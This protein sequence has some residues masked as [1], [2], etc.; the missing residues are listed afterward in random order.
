MPQRHRA[1]LRSS[2]DVS[3][4]ISM[5][6]VLVPLVAVTCALIS[7][8]LT[9]V[10]LSEVSMQ[11]WLPWPHLCA[12]ATSWVNSETANELCQACFVGLCPISKTK[13]KKNQWFSFHFQSG[14]I[15]S[16]IDPWLNEW[17]HKKVATKISI[18]DIT[19]CIFHSA[20]TPITVALGG[21]H[22]QRIIGI[23]SVMGRRARR[24]HN[25]L[26]KCF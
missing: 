15:A 3:A 14:G 23:S 4:K 18:M 6:I 16:E 2:F 7:H 5:F 24:W 25:S 8:S 20:I 22:S 12:S 10:F 19:S 13:G 1:S 11:N 17:C 9:V 21:L 26:L